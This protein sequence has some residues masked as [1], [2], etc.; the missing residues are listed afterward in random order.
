[1]NSL[2]FFESKLKIP[3][4]FTCVFLFAFQ[5][6]VFIYSFG[7]N[8]PFWDDYDNIPYIESFVKGESFWEIKR[9]WTQGDHNYFFPS[10][11]TLT[12]VALTSWNITY[13]LYFGLSLVV[14]STFLL[15][16][17]L[18]DLDSRL[19]WAIIPISAFLFNPIQF[20][21]FLWAFT[22]QVFIFSTT[23]IIASIFFLSKIKCNRF[24]FIPS[25]LFAVIASFSMLAG[26]I[27]WVIG[28]G[29][30]YFQRQKKLFSIW[31]ISAVIV[32][33]IYF[34]NL[35][36]SPNLSSSNVATIFN[37]S[38]YS[39][40]FYYVSNGLLIDSQILQFFAGSVII[41]IIIAGSIFL[42]LKKIEF[43]KIWPWIQIGFVGLL[44]AFIT[45]VGRLEIGGPS[46]SRYT[47]LAN[48]AE[49][50][51]LVIGAILF[52]RI[53]DSKQSK[54]VKIIFLIILVVSSILLA[55]TLFVTYKEGW[56][57]GN[58]R[59]SGSII[60]LECMYKPDTDLR[61]G[62]PVF[63]DPDRLHDYAQ[64]L[65]NLH[66]SPFSI[67]GH[68]IFS[69]DRLLKDDSWSEMEKIDGAGKIEYINGNNILQNEKINV[70]KEIGLIHATGW[71]SFNNEITVDSAYLFIDD[72]VNSRAVYNIPQN[73]TAIFLHH[74]DKTDRWI[75]SV[76][77]A[78]LTSG[79]HE[80]SLRIVHESKFYESIA[81][82]QLCIN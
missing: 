71:A 36:T 21:T 19:V 61:C 46:A 17:M 23:S 26:L 42:K 25:I 79:C 32:F 67:Q 59:N 5:G 68:S 56:N 64:I 40:I 8:I 76:D 11:S 47:T 13:L 48:P 51:A 82:S 72:H 38:D 30:F 70:E 75:S 9:F 4:I 45:M 31:L 43:V 2:K 49:I 12:S 50:S 58:I 80:V 20:E 57:S 74:P 54:S 63:P 15:Y 3:I 33:L 73:S 55:Y 22:A 16:L 27:V 39:Y 37:L 7:V 29:T 14:I 18:K 24:F 78:N 69:D 44:V 62:P 35:Q 41:S 28:A 53:I 81:P 66:L 6:F 60:G 52:I 65:L 77:L 34:D 1:M 10:I